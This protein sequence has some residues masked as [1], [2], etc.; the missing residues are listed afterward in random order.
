MNYKNIV[1][2]ILTIVCFALLMVVCKQHEALKADKEI[3]NDWELLSI[4]W[5]NSMD[6]CMNRNDRLWD[7]LMSLKEYKIMKLREEQEGKK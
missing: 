2:I 6:T 4:K 1:I 5:R 7:E 3:I